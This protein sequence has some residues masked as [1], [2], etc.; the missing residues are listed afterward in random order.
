MPFTGHVGLSLR[1]HRPRRSHHGRQSGLHSGGLMA[2]T[3]TEALAGVPGAD[4]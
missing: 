1:N 2:Y 4:C 3:D